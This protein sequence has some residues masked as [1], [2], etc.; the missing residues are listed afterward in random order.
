MDL[1]GVAGLLVGIWGGWATWKSRRK[2]LMVYCISSS[3]II[4]DRINSIPGLKIMVG[5]EF[6]SDLTLTKIDFYNQGNV[7][8]KGNVNINGSDFA[9]RSPLRIT[10]TGRF[11]NLEAINEDTIVSDNP[12]LNP[13]IIITDKNTLNLTFEYLKP[14][15]SFSISLL[16]DG[17]VSVS[18]DLKSG[19]LRQRQDTFIPEEKNTRSNASSFLLRISVITVLLLTLFTACLP[20]QNLF[21]VFHDLAPSQFIRTNDDPPAQN[22]S[23]SSSEYAEMQSELVKIQVQLEALRAQDYM[24]RN[25]WYQMYSLNAKYDRIIAYLALHPVEPSP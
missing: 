23:I 5:D 20:P 8:I 7:N 13:D 10:S 3:R 9:T 21:Q 1:L 12:N 19:K 4:T 2:Q 18:G 25:D 15:E 6:I 14:K 24:D 16:H 22:T 17:E 11:F